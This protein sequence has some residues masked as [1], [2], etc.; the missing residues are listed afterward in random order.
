VYFKGFYFYVWIHIADQAG[1]PSVFEHPL[2][3]LYHFNCNYYQANAV[4]IV[5]CC[6]VM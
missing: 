5:T 6:N 3:F 4:I 2:I 1:H